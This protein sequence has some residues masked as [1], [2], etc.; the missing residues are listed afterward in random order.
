M[1]EC[2]SICYNISKIESIIY[3]DRVELSCSLP[4]IAV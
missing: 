4:V 1:Y 2:V 3:E